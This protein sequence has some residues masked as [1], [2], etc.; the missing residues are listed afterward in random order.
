MFLSLQGFSLWI[1][2][3][4]SLRPALYFFI[5]RRLAA[6]NRPIFI[7]CQALIPVFIGI[8]FFYI[9][10][11]FFIFFW[12]SYSSRISLSALLSHY[13]F[14]PLLSLTLLLSIYCKFTAFSLIPSFSTC[15]AFSLFIPCL[16]SI[17]VVFNTEFRSLYS[18]PPLCAKLLLLA[19]LSLQFIGVLSNLCFL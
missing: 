8:A 11:A 17:I 15:F 12:S 3:I 9:T 18:L 1:R 16:L 5:H 7:V 19:L 13:I 2:P 4:F 6:R 10:I 14:C